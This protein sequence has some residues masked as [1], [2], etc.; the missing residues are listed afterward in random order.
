MSLEERAEIFTALFGSALHGGGSFLQTSARSPP[1]L[2][3]F[4]Y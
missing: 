4:R 3:S 2:P 1:V